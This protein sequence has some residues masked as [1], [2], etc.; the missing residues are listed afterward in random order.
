MG[1]FS[2]AMTESLKRAEVMQANA[3]LAI[4]DAYGVEE[5]KMLDID[6]LTWEM[7][8]EI[9]DKAD[10]T[11]RREELENELRTLAAT[12]LTQILTQPQEGTP[13]G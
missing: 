8:S 6:G 5:K 13:N 10:R 11:G 9:L 1:L 7:F 12:A 2:R 4:R 3:V